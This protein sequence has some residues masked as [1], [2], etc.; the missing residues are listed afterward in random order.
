MLK[1]EDHWEIAAKRNEV[2]TMQE[3]RFHGLDQGQC[4]IGYLAGMRIGGA[5]P[6][7]D[8]AYIAA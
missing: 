8:Q 6:V 1:P 5:V 7:G 3:I 4:S 2:C